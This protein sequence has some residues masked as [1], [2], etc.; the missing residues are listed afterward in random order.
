V[1]I[2][3][4]KGTK[5]KTS[6]SNSAQTHNWRNGLTHIRSQIHKQF[7]QNIEQNSIDGAHDELST[8][9]Q[10]DIAIEHISNT[11]NLELTSSEILQIHKTITDEIRGLGPLAVLMADPQISD[12]LVNGPKDVWID[13][14]GKLQK[15]KIIFDD[16][17]HVRRVLDR[18]VSESGKHLDIGSPS[19]DAKLYDGSRL[20]AVIPPLC[21]S[22]PII[23]IRRFRQD[24][25][26]LTTLVAQGV[27]NDTMQTFLINAVH[28]RMNIVI[29]GGAGA[30]KTTLLKIL[31]SHIPDDERVI[32]I[33]ETAEMNI[34]HPHVISLETRSVNTELR[35]D[36][37]LRDLVRNALR[38]RADR[39][40]VG[41]VRGEE[42]M[43]M[44]QAMNV[45]HDGSLTTVHANSVSEVVMRLETLALLSSS[46]IPKAAITSMIVA[47]VDLII[48]VARFSDGKRRI[49]SI[50]EQCLSDGKP[51]LR[52]LFQFKADTNCIK[53][54][55]GSHITLAE[56][57]SKKLKR[58]DYQA[59]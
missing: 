35:G 27:L 30:G 4:D 54:I 31:A 49:T 3:T 44:L 47:A 46:N 34:Q 52:E 53:Q 15:S 2:F 19:V 13:K 7:L 40:I 55:N 33:E 9:K 21:A 57:L 48:H 12:I 32:A 29:A 41:E 51:H 42:V 5:E 6:I 16:H 36:I 43:D 39:I 25:L 1:N 11:L 23:S 17:A 22:G 59:Q 28:A 26:D 45:G 18:L 56:P 50:A 24:I 38:M 37:S 8:K 10:L 14:N 20:H 58:E